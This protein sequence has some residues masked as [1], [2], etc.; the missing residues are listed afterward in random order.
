MKDLI[1]VNYVPTVPVCFTHMLWLRNRPLRQ[2]SIIES[3]ETD[4]YIYGNLIYDKHS[5]SKNSDRDIGSPLK[6]LEPKLH[7]KIGS[8]WNIELNIKIKC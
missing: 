8:R 6:M 7:P 3:L 4:S 1:D 5:I 2:W